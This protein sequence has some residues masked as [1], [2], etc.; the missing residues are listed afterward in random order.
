MSTRGVGA[1]MI[2]VH[3]P[4]S[5]RDRQ[6][7]ADR[8][9]RGAY[10]SREFGTMR[11]PATSATITTGTFTRKTEPHQKWS[12]SQPPTTGPIA[13]PR[14]ETPAQIADGAAALL[15][16]EDVREDR[17][18]RRH[19]ERA[20]DAHE[21]ARRDQHGRAMRRER[22]SS[23]PAAKITQPEVEGAPATEAVAEAPGREQQPGEHEDVGVDDPLQLAGGAS[24]SR[25]SVGSATFKIVLSSPITS[26]LRQRTAEDPPAPLVP[27]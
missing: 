27:F 24:R 6:H 23:E 3:E 25:T 19:D 16:R 14:P 1:S 7:G 2:A 11:R 5:A 18:G 10:G 26:R 13:M 8:V 17:Q 20:A 15:R 22:G 21:R 9:E 4:P 12:S